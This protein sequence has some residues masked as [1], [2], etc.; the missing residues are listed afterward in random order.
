MKSKQQ[1][2]S[3]NNYHN[4]L[5]LFGFIYY[6]V[7]PVVIGQHGLMADFPGMR[8]FYED[9]PTE[10]KLDNYYKLICIIFI[11]F[12]LGS[13]ASLYVCRKQHKFSRVTHHTSPEPSFAG[14][15]LIA[16]GIIN[17]YVIFKARNFLFTGYLSG[18]HVETLGKLATLMEL[19]IFMYMYMVK[20]GVLKKWKYPLVLLIIENA[21][22]LMGL[23]SRMYVLIPVVGYTILLIDNRL[24]KTKVLIPVIVGFV[25]FLLILGILREGNNKFSSEAL[26]Y[27]AFAEPLFTWLSAKSFVVYNSSI[28]L[29]EYPANFIGTFVNFIPSFLFPNK[30]DFIPDVPYYYEAPMGAT[31]IV[32]SMYGN[33]GLVL[34]PIV[35][36]CGGWILSRLRYT[37]SAF[38]QV[39]YYCCCSLIPF[40]LFRDLQSTNKLLFTSFL[41]FPAII[42]YSTN[43]SKQKNK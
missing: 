3:L 26:T 1:S 6:L 37:Q 38:F 17:Q 4:W 5:F 41:I 15:F 36:F 23:G 8:L 13:Y 2:Y 22:I 27:M 12:Y 39:Y 11:S 24:V 34:T 30:A 42:L 33:F 16:L 35:L 29:I 25:V 32:L 18:Y 21:L 31:S 10:R 7:I 19:Y 20:A 9:F 40:I 14:I 43:N 28:K